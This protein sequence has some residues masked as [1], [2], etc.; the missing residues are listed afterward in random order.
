MRKLFL[1]AGLIML[2]LAPNAPAANFAFVSEAH[3]SS[4]GGGGPVDVTINSTGA[5]V[6]VA[7]LSC[8]YGSAGYVGSPDFAGNTWTALTAKTQVGGSQV[9]LWYSIP[10][11]V[12]AGHVIRFTSSTSF[13]GAGYVLAFSGG[14]A[15]PFEAEGAGATNS[16][17]TI[18]PGSLTP[19]LNNELVV[20]ALS[21][22]AGTPTISGMTGSYGLASSGGNH[23]GVGIAYLIQ[24]TAAASNPTWDGGGSSD[25]SAVIACFKS[26]SSSGTSPV[27]R[28]VITGGE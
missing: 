8:D 15:S 1:F 14:A 13:Y 4:T 27:K 23:Y 5:N 10:T 24:T 26:T 25:N 11:S 22:Y 19:A 28:R 12:G 2:F 9:Q 18:Q 17:A 3:A 20:T 7:V 21:N 6:L 16:G